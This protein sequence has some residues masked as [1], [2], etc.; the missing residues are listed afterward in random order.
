MI[1]IVE[2]DKDDLKELTEAARREGIPEEKLRCFDKADE[3]WRF[4]RDA[5]RGRDFPAAVVSD[6]L[7]GSESDHGASLLWKTEE[8]ARRE[9]SGVWTFLVTGHHSTWNDREDPW[10]PFSMY[11]KSSH[12]WADRLAKALAALLKPGFDEL[13][14]DNDF[15]PLVPC[16][17]AERIYIYSSGGADLFSPAGDSADV[18]NVFQLRGEHDK[19]STIIAMYHGRHIVTNQSAA[20]A[21]ALLRWRTLWRDYINSGDTRD[22]R[23]P[24]LI[25]DMYFWERRG[26]DKYYLT[27]EDPFDNEEMRLLSLHNE[28]GKFRADEQIKKLGERLF[29]VDFLPALRAVQLK[30]DKKE[31]K[32]AGEKTAAGRRGREAVTYDHK[33]LNVRSYCT[34]PPPDGVRWKITDSFMS[35]LHFVLTEKERNIHLRW[36]ENR[37]EMAALDTPDSGRTA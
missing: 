30:E 24:P 23:Q 3:A 11:S 18:P 20:V 9:G 22:G 26:G 33:K 37:R 21:R 17:L 28:V 5:A 10:H 31:D 14:S 6:W 16:P 7:L 34:L 35:R 2:N 29:G 13:D 12:G 4:I 8:V 27:E 32:T 36:N 1:T 25:K 19:V 15:A